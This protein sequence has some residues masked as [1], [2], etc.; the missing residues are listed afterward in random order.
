MNLIH[1][2]LNE[3]STTDS[4]FQSRHL[5]GIR[6]LFAWEEFISWFPFAEG[7]HLTFQSVIYSKKKKDAC[8]TEN[9][10]SWMNAIFLLAWIDVEILHTNILMK[11]ELY[12][13]PFD[14]YSTK[15]AND[16]K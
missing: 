12:H 10:N 1:E 4:W 7:C 5:L 8:S 13:S 6:F 2:T 9:R 16:Y 3:F 15:Q 14:V 11:K